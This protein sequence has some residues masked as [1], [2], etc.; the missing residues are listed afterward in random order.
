MTI[1]VGGFAIGACLAALLPGTAVFASSYH[2]QSSALPK[3]RALSQRS[4]VYDSAGTKIGELGTKDR[5]DVTLD[6]VPKIIQNAVIAV[7]DKT[8]WSND[9]I[10][11]NSVFRAALKDFSSG[12]I[13]QGG[14][15]IT[16]QLVKERI[17]NAKRAV[18]RK[19][20]EIVLALRLTQKYSK[21]Q[22]LQQ[23]LNTVYFGQGSY[24]IKAAAERLF[25]HPD[26]SAPFG[27]APT[28]LNQV[29]VGEA[30]LLAGLIN[31]P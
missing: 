26:P 21:R 10:D 28:K 8:F 25:V 24:G 18:H 6:Q 30:A 5:R 7:E 4:T 9:G 15:T 13:V 14:S 1:L 23:Y 11:L 3:L 27:V 19:V 20:K 22:V 31:N 17:L 12:Q 29:T 2:Y 16:Q